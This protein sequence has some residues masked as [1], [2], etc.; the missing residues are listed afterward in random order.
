MDIRTWKANRDT[1]MAFWKQD[2]TQKWYQRRLDDERKYVDDIKRKNSEAGKA[3]ALKKHNRHST[4]VATKP[5]PESN[6]HTLP[7]PIPKSRTVKKQ[8]IA[9]T[10]AFESLYELYPR[11][12][13]SK[14][15]AFSAYQRIINEGVEHGR[16]E[17]G[18]RAFADYVAREAVERRYVAHAATWLNQRRWESDYGSKP[19]PIA[20]PTEQPTRSDRARAA[21]EQALAEI[22][23]SLGG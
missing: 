18:I 13:G 9:Y 22:N 14:S 3:S 2:A 1:I 16:I 4:T 12:D 23:Q 10:S 7:T 8:S 19:T 11:K 5:Q 15:D 20:K 17:S 6:P 21:V